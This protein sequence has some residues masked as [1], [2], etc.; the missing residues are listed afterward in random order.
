MPLFRR[1][2]A[3]I[4]LIVRDSDAA[5][6]ENTLF[7]ADAFDLLYAEPRGAYYTPPDFRWRH[8]LRSI[9]LRIVVHHNE[10]HTDAFTRLRHLHAALPLSLIFS[11]PLPLPPLIISMPY[12]ISP[13]AAFP[14]RLFSFISI[15][16]ISLMILM[17]FVIFAYFDVYFSLMP[18]ARFCQP[19]SSAIRFAFA[20]DC[21]LLRR[22]A[23]LLLMFYCCHAA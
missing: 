17:F 19:A 3:T 16:F 7:A 10:R 12:A 21:S 22:C 4:P 14:L 23:M 1:A 6:R 13:P 2:A 11:S 15:S 9:T 18:D 20:I 8:Y 5:T